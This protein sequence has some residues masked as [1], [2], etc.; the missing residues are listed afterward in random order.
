L[1]T[2]NTT[3]NVTLLT[4]P[5]SE[6]PYLQTTVTTLRINFTEELQKGSGVITV[7]D[8]SNGSSWQYNVSSA[9]TILHK[10]IDI[11]INPLTIGTAYWVSVPTG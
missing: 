1:T 9:V 10:A 8:R 5:D 6:V 2:G 4:P 7:Y 3:P 11:A